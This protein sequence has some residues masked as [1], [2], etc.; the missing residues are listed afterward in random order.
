MLQGGSVGT[1][2]VRAGG[3]ELNAQQCPGAV[4]RVVHLELE[5]LLQAGQQQA[6]WARRLG[7][8]HGIT[9]GSKDST[10]THDVII[11]MV[12]NTGN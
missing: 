11:A 6:P 10:R 8:K 1:W 3:E 7:Q 12:K 2:Y 5:M 4:H 9:P